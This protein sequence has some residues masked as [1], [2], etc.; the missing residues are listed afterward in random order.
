[1]KNWALFLILTVFLTGCSS[2]EKTYVVTGSV[3]YKGTPVEKGSITFLADNASHGAA[4]VD[5]R[6]TCDA[7]LGH[8]TVQITGS[9]RVKPSKKDDQSLVLYE[10]FIPEKYNLASELTTE[11]QGEGEQNF[12]L[13]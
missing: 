7:T 2:E 6:Y 12:N 5:G 9:K 1:M 11:I 10:D 13:E 3:T 4:I 8:K